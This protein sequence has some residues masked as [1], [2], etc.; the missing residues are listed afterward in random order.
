LFLYGTNDF[1]IYR[2]FGSHFDGDGNALNNFS[3]IS[4]SGLNPSNVFPVGADSLVIVS[5]SNNQYIPLVDNDNLSILVNYAGQVINSH[6]FGSNTRDFAFAAERVGANNILWGGATNQYSTPDSTN[7]YIYR[8]PLL[9][10]GTCMKSYSVTTGEVEV[11][12]ATSIPTSIVE[13]D[14]LTWQSGQAGQ[15]SISIQVLGN[16]G[17]TSSAADLN[18]FCIIIAQGFDKTL[19][20]VSELAEGE[21]RLSVTDLSGRQLI[22]AIVNNNLTAAQLTDQLPTG[23]YAYTMTFKGCGGVQQVTGKLPVVR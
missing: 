14:T 8:T 12:V 11:E 2:L 3:I 1:E 15:E 7:C 21:I 17:I 19:Q 13:T 16:C 4:Q 23:W 10:G 9:G 6:A 18:N 22:Q 20:Q 5:T